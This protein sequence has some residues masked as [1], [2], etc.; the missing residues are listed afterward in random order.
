[1]IISWNLTKLRS[2]LTNFVNNIC[3]IKVL[4]GK[5]LMGSF[6]H[7]TQTHCPSLMNAMAGVSNHRPHVVC[8]TIYS[9]ADQRKH[10]SSASLAFV[11]GIHRWPLTGEFHALSPVIRKMFLFDVIMCQQK[12]V[13][14]QLLIFFY[15]NI[16]TSHSVFAGFQVLKLF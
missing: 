2:Q 14:I 4:M 7:I 16:E 11:C 9:G 5:I 10:Q 1:M 6:F 13:A 15:W 12:H 8:S 3:N